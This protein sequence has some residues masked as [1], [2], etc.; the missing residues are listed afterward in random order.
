MTTFKPLIPETPNTN[1]ETLTSVRQT[2]EWLRAHTGMPAL[3]LATL[4]RLGK[5]C[6]L[7]ARAMG[8]PT[9]E[10]P[11]YGQRWSSEKTYTA[12]VLREAFRLHPVTAPWYAQAVPS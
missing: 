8:R 7:A 1:N 6:S 11:V 4:S 5:D 9:G 12:D 2:V 3:D 10:T